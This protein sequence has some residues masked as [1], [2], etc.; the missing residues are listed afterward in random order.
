MAREVTTT[1]TLK[2]ALSEFTEEDLVG[3]QAA[4]ERVFA[5]FTGRIKRIRIKRRRVGSGFRRLLADDEVYV[6]V[7]LEAENEEVAN[8]LVEE[9]SQAASDPESASLQQL[10]AIL[11]EEGVVSEAS[12]TVSTPEVTVTV[13]TSA[14]PSAI[15]EDDPLSSAPR[16]G[17]SVLSL[18]LSL[19]SVIATLLM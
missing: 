16:T 14:S 6:E 12:F 3:F 17:F 2:G 11:E 15:G 5:D 4:L 8:T 7:V 18:V 9:I 19:A 13:S 10:G 1:F